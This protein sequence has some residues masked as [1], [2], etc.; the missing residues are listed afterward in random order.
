MLQR[1]DQF[2]R[3]IFAIIVAP[4]AQQGG[5]LS[6]LLRIIGGLWRLAL[7]AAQQIVD[8]GHAVSGGNRQYL[9]Q[10]VGVERG[11]GHFG[12]VV[13]AQVK[14]YRTILVPHHQ[15][16][17]RAGRRQCDHQG[18]EHPRSL[19]GITMADE[20]TPRLVDQHLVEFGLDRIADPQT[21]GRRVEDRG[22]RLRPVTAADINAV[23]ANL[24]GVAHRSIDD[25][26]GATAIGGLLRGSG[27]L[28]RLSRQQRQRNWADPLHRQRRREQ[29]DFTARVEVAGAAGFAQEVGQ[30]GHGGGHSNTARMWRRRSSPYDANRVTTT[31]PRGGRIRSGARTI[32][33]KSPQVAN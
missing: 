10:T 13:D 19:F 5:E 22:E 31:D 3:R 6:L 4:V 23:R 26:I 12:R 20:E 15:F 32:R 7:A 29:L 24:Q 27:Q 2:L 9:V 30:L 11:K 8:Q 16:A 28:F 1:I 18:G 25:G 14:G 21:P 17:T 33:N